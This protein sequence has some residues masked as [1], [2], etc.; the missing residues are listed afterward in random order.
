MNLLITK[1]NCRIIGDIMLACCF[2]TLAWLLKDADEQARNFGLIIGC[3]AIFIRLQKH[4]PCKKQF[5]R[6]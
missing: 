6:K 3:A 4:T 2:L 5:P 1:F